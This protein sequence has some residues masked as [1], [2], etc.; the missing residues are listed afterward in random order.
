MKVSVIIPVFN[1]E[2]YIGKCLKSLREQNIKPDEIIV[3]DNF[4]SDNSVS[5]IKTFGVRLIEERTQGISQARNKGFDTANYEII[6]RCDADSIVPTNWIQTIK[7]NFESQTIDGLVGPILY[8]DLP[9]QGIVYSKM[10][11]YFMRLIQGYHTIFGNNMAISR[12]IWKKVRDGVCMDNAQVHEDIDLA[13]HIHRYGGIV[14]YDPLFTAMTSGRRISK[15]L[16]SFLIEYPRRLISTLR[17]D[18]G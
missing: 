4:S 8:Y 15:H 6:A 10:F 16:S 1:E 13:I 7:R 3:V 2:K 18:H 17:T 14:K 12:S 9:F 5:I 11:I